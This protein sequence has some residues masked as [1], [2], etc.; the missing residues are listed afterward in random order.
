[1]KNLVIKVGGALLDSPELAQQFFNT[2]KKLQ[3]THT[4]VLVHGGG[5]TVNQLLGDLGFQS[6]KLDGLRVTPTDQ[7]P[8]VVGALS[9]TV[10]KTLCSFAIKAGIK[11]VGG[12]LLDGGSCVAEKI[13]DEL[14]AVGKVTPG[15]KDYL[16]ALINIGLLPIISSIGATNAGDLMNVNADD[17]AAVVA[18]LL[19]AELVLLSDVAGVL[20]KNKV[21]L[22]QL[23]QNQI[24][25]L[26]KDE[27]IT[28]GMAV[29]VRAA[30]TTANQISAPVT[31]ASWKSPE[32]LLALATNQSAGTKI[33]PESIHSME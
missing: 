15:S 8:Y 10:N 32:Q 25:Q 27:V 20:D 29:K 21:L 33:V 31:I 19:S 9:G 30:L 28:D 2:L 24:D 14:G 17:A 18:Q 1:M 11:P 12:S 13:N 5:N 16:E 26:I 4:V 22:S 6:K 3:Q 7:L 23:S